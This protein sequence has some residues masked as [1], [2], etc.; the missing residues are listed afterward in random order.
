[1]MKRIVIVACALALA[2]FASAQ[3][4]KYVDKDGKTV[5]TDQPPPGSEP[6]QMNVPSSA[7]GSSPAPAKSAVQ[8]DKELQKARDKAQ[9]GTKKADETAARAKAEE[10]RCES[11][12]TAYTHYAQGGRISKYNAQGERIF[13]GDAEIDAERER[14]KQKMEEVCK[15]S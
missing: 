5:Y 3:M 11:A 2:P 9:E 15:K 1:M 8:Q 6:K 7:T 14:A 10:E 12:K 13:L 4:Y